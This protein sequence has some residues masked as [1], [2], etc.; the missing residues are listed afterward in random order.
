[1]TSTTLHSNIKTSGK[2]RKRIAMA[3]V[4]LL[5][6]V[7][8]GM[9]LRAN[10]VSSTTTFNFTQAELN[11][12]WGPERIIPSGGYSSVG[13][14]AGRTNVAEIRIDSFNSATD[15]YHRTEGIKTKY[16]AT[17]NFSKPGNLGQSV[18]VDLYL[19]PVWGTK[20]VRAGMWSV[21][22]NGSNGTDAGNYPFGI[23]EFAHVE[24]YEGFRFAGNNNW[25]KTRAFEGYGKWVTLNVSL[26]STSHKYVYSINGTKVGYANAPKV[27][28]YLYSVILNQRNFGRDPQ[29]NLSATS[30]D[31]HWH[32]SAA[33][34]TEPDDK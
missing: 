12:N 23:L 17:D 15:T 28:T 7:I 6:L 31:V 22:D 11:D 16:G 26:D 4:G 21:G 3:V 30:Y 18:S 34:Q 13:P 2:L 8:V 33:S 9:T 19:D 1:M 5:L 14:F 25:V 29:A 10:A 27:S 24:G 20:A 32:G